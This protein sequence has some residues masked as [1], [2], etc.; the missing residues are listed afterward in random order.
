MSFVRGHGRGLGWVVAHFRRPHRAQ[1][2]QLRLP[3]PGVDAAREDPAPT[4]AA[5]SAPRRA[6]TS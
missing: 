3:V 4:T 1:I 6:E 2:D 5:V